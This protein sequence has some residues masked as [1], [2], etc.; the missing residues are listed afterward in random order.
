M[1]NIW[2]KPPVENEL[3]LEE[4][5]RFFFSSN[6]FSWL[7]ITGG[8]PFLKENL[9]DTIDIVLK[10]CSRL[11]HIHFATNGTCLPRIKEIVAHIKNKKPS[12][13]IAFTVSLDGPPDLHNKIRGRDDVWEKAIE[14]FIYLKSLPGPVTPRIGFT[15]SHQN[16]NS[17]P[18]TWQ[19]I[20]DNF[21]ALS[22]DDLTINIFQKSGFYYDN[23]DT[24]L[25]DNT[26]LIK[27]IK[28]I[29]NMDKE[30][31]SINSYIRRTYLK[32]YTKYLKTQKCP[33]PCKALSSTC[34]LDPYGDIYPCAIFN[35]KLCNIKTNHEELSKLW[36]SPHAKQLSYECSN[37]ICPSCWSPCDAYSAIAGSLYKSF[38]EAHKYAQ[39]AH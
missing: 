36:D 39:V 4:L 14:T 24:P 29:L 6:A 1:C 15:I 27:T 21:P 7:G 5:E 30:K 3:S 22:F 38:T 2:E 28:N 8:E 25:L 37:N 35:K 13:A 26:Q 18:Q 31:L 11:S 17:F 34:F 16:M 33:L 19:A 10:H 9:K 12:L 32:L 20:K 23:L